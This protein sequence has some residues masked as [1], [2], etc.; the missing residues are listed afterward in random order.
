MFI[1]VI[2]ACISLC[3]RGFETV[4]AAARRVRLA[5]MSSDI[6]SRAPKKKRA[7]AAGAAK[8][9]PAAV[10]VWT[11]ALDAALDAA[12]AEWITTQAFGEDERFATLVRDKAT[13]ETTLRTRDPSGL[14][15]A[16]A[17]NLC[18]L[19]QSR[20]KSHVYV[21]CRG[22]HRRKVEVYL[23]PLWRILRWLG[24]TDERRPAAP[25]P[26][27]RGPLR[28]SVQFTSPT[29][30]EEKPA[31]P[32]ALPRPQTVCRPIFLPPPALPELEPCGADNR[33]A[34]EC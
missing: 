10:Y 24:I 3:R 27:P 15:N 25:A 16:A 34:A 21:P 12:E 14:Q 13:G 1:T 26:P 6:T 30:Q 5:D 20:R 9:T 31:T 29:P 23:Y 32:R 2:L 7:K 33:P 28:Q 18:G 19:Y 8:Q 11:P 17:K 4:P 22:G